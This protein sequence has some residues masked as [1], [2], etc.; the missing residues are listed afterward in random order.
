[1][2]SFIFVV[3]V[4]NLCLGLVVAIHLG[5]RYRAM[6]TGGDVWNSDT[7]LDWPGLATPTPRKDAVE[8]LEGV[9]PPLGDSPPRDETDDSTT[10]D[11]IAAPT[12]AD[13]AD[14]TTA[15]GTTADGADSRAVAIDSVADTSTPEAE[16]DA[17]TG[18]HVDG[19]MAEAAARDIAAEAAARDIAAED[20][21]RDIAAEDAARDIAAEDA[22]RDIAAEDAAR[23][24]AAEDAA[25]GPMTKAAASGVTAEETTADAVVEGAAGDVTAEDTSTGELTEE[26]VTSAAATEGAAADAAT[27]TSPTE[28]GATRAEPAQAEQAAPT[29]EPAV[30]SAGDAK[31]GEMSPVAAPPEQQLTKSPS[32]MIIE[33]FQLE[34]EQYL[35]QVTEADLELRARAEKP[36]PAVIETCLGSLKD[37]TADYLVNRGKAH[38]SFRWMNR[39]RPELH[40]I[41][42]KLQ[43]AVGL[44]DQQIQST[45][46][47]IE[48]FDYQHNLKRGCKKMVGETGKLMETSHNLRDTLD[49]ARVEVARHEKRLDE[50]AESTRRDDDGGLSDRAGMEA[51]L[52]KWWEQDPDG[53]RKL[54]LAMIDVDRFTRI[55]EQYGHPVGD[56]IL[57]AIAQFLKSEK[58][59]KSMPVRL[60]GQRFLFLFPDFDSRW[61]T[62]A[63]ERIRQ[64]IEIARFRYRD[65]DIRI[66][67]SCAVVQAGSEDTSATLVARA[68]ATLQEAKRYGRNRTFVHQGKY[69]T[70]LVPPNLSLDEKEITL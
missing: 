35:D 50:L 60:S 59:A 54:Y 12:R 14:G 33:D 20:A 16:R 53:T 42:D 27:K 9:E 70:P 10:T 7:G 41:N 6:V 51:Y 64:S 38:M 29:P 45:N 69:P 48:S 5:R 15:D 19:E 65:C 46:E 21:A 40:Q 44:Q 63:V 62:N 56:R 18:D 31:P 52:A 8:G 58:R 22:A 39:R 23:D 55:N 43:A 47:S 36:D 11:A 66:T 25:T 57:H 49:E 61:A 4:L 13:A 37:A 68:E 1:V 34:V 32:Q 28:D 2:I 30:G 24:I 17:T 67:V 26:D 3:A